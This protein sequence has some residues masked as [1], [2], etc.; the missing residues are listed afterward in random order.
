MLSKMVNFKD[1][2][3]EIEE[4]TKEVK[5]LRLLVK[6]HPEDANLQSV[7]QSKEKCLRR[8]M[9]TDGIRQAHELT[10]DR[11]NKV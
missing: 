11:T 6:N 4:L 9:R 7:L 3:P 5:E 1:L 8:L 2:K 10:L